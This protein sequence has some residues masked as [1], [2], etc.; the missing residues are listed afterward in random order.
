MTEP[1]EY[2]SVSV[3]I[4][5][6]F[7]SVFP[8]LFL[9][10]PVI[11]WSQTA[12]TTVIS[13]KP[14]V[15]AYD[16]KLLIICFEIYLWN[17]ELDY[18]WKSRTESKPTGSRKGP[19]LDSLTLTWACSRPWCTHWWVESNLFQQVGKFP[20]VLLKHSPW[21]GESKYTVKPGPSSRCSCPPTPP[22]RPSASQHEWPPPEGRA[23]RPLRLLSSSKTLLFPSPTPGPKSQ[24]CARRGGFSPLRVKMVSLAAHSVTSY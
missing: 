12:F 14:V 1:N 3:L 18:F 11:Q 8:R 5:Q 2:C 17:T 13:L 10:G 6:H 22:G 16:R 21:C 20:S 24:T 19:P 4:T 7:G 15:Q 23:G 9:I